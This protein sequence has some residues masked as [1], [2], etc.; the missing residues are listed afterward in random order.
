MDLNN[1]RSYS[2]KELSYL[3]VLIILI[4]TIFNQEGNA[5]P[6]SRAVKGITRITDTVKIKPCIVRLDSVWCFAADPGEQG[7]TRKW[8]TNDF[9]DSNWK[10]ICSGTS[11]QSQGI[12]HY[13]WGWYRQ[14]LFVPK[15]CEGLS[16]ILKLGNIPSDDDAFVNGVHVG[17]IKGEYKYKNMQQR[18][19]P[20]P[21]SVLRYG[22]MNTIAVRVWG[23]SLTFIGSKSGLITGPFLAEFDPFSIKIREPGLQE[24]Q[25]IELSDFSHA[26]RE[27]PFEMIFRFPEG[28]SGTRQDR[29]KYTVRDFYGKEITSGE[30][31]LSREQDGFLCGIADVDGKTAQ[32]IYLRG[33]IMIEW[34]VYNKAGN[35][36]FHKTNKLDH[37]N[38][39][40]RDTLSLPA[41]KE[42]QEVTPY[43]TLRLVDE[44]DCS[45]SL[46]EE[47][48]PY[49]QS[50]FDEDQR[51]NTPGSTLDV[52]ISEI[53]GK[54][55]RESGNGWFAYR[56]GRGKL[57]PH[58]TYL[59]RIEY[60]EDKPRYCPVE[61]QVGQNYM[62]VG[63]QN[64]VVSNDPYN[65]WPLSNAWQW[66]DVIVPLD[67]ETV[68]TGGT[69]SASAEH[70]F[71]VYFL[72]KL[73]NPPKYY[74]MYEGGPAVARIKLYEIDAEKNA[75]AIRTPE[76]LPQRTLMFDWE[77]QADHEPADLIRYAKLMGYNVISPLILKWAF[78]NYSEPLNGY[79]S[80]NIDNRNYWAWN[81]YKPGAGVNTKSP[82]PGK[83]SIHI[84]YLK[85]TKE[86]D[87]RY[88]PRI[89]YGGSMDLPEEAKAIAKDGKLAKP[90]R[91][92]PWCSDLLNLLTFED[93]RR[94]LDHLIK[95]YAENN[96]Q[97]SGVLWRIRSNR[98]P[99]SYSRFDIELFSRE[100]GISYPTGTDEALGTWASTGEIGEKYADWW[101]QKRRDFHAQLTGL[102]KN[103]RP[104]LTLYYYNWDN[105]KFGLGLPDTHRWA[106]LEKVAFAPEGKAK[107]VYLKDRADRQK[108]KPNDYI[109]IMYS[110]N[111]AGGGD[112][113][114]PDY[115]LR[116]GLYK[117]LPGIRLLAP[118]NSLPLADN[119][120]YLNYFQTADGVAV[121]NAVSYDE[122]GA[123]TINPK[124][125]GHMIT[126]GGAPFSM[127]FEVLSWFHADA[128][129]LSYT[130]YTYGRGFADAHRRFAQAFLA[131]PAV[132]GTVLDSGDQDVKI[133]A[134][135][136]GN[137]T[138]L[139]IANKAYQ[140]KKITVK[141]PANFMN[142]KK[143]ITVTDLVSGKMIPAERKENELQFV[144]TSGPMELNSFLIS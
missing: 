79:T 72:N 21:A 121:S 7:M 17:G 69:G 23:G 142:G 52:K 20:V 82:L 132:D 78:A 118:A 88:V 141:L 18:E 128:R 28:R 25:D 120:E 133:R 5:E 58:H 11:W 70:G 92:A 83:E 62:D 106:F 97:L 45:Q 63:W 61:I 127:A 138:Y 71:W 85:A 49:L 13:G 131:L 143:S 43:G 93:M 115:A 60:P 10:T 24:Y 94:L 47:I 38:F 117:D 36:L 42:K 113:N 29:L 14:K 123:R 109:K 95:P 16:L 105:D 81:E 87:I 116:P 66:Y 33:R 53:L 56:I 3:F 55:A 130:V 8:Y 19:Y 27:Q 15:E 99:I 57:T 30:V 1:S 135:S 137:G 77:R 41:L 112:L 139:G 68:G 100:T 44:I 65:N 84:R 4:L 26:Q 110:G 51:F 22:Q 111:F 90:N 59:L 75:P 122:V 134:Y 140:S 67:D 91:F 32:T 12:D 108:I 80:V 74:A 31:Q 125:E 50:G 129:T 119:P 73:S 96:P 34:S 37:L 35:L 103:Y 54:K 114:S 76:G 144:I 124:F 40:Q 89:E 64:G 9:D 104:D 102:I 107:D 48:H 136:N 6:R 2:C 98:M 39:S 126:P 46:T 101:H 86:L